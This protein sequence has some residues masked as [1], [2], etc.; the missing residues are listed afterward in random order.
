M[1]INTQ[2][3]INANAETIWNTLLDFA[4]YY[5]WNPF[6]TKIE[7]VP[8]PNHKLKVQL[9]TMKF[10]PVVQQCIPHQ[11]LAWL[12][13]LG[14]KGIFDGYHSFE[15]IPITEHRC[16]F[17]HCENFSGILVPL[18]KNKL[19]RETRQVLF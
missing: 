18:F 4:N 6:I 5:K 17:I 13:Q 11:K 8:I 7:G 1:K 16:L 14:I 9:A 19:N 12:G 15:I 2:I 3:E 10:S